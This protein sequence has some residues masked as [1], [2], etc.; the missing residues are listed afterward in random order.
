MTAWAIASAVLSIM[1][2]LLF[3]RLLRWA[4]TRVVVA[5]RDLIESA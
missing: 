2:W 1:A 5:W 3:C 4:I